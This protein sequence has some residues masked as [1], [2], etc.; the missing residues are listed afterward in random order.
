ML[1]AFFLLTLMDMDTR[2]GCFLLQELGNNLYKP[3]GC[4]LWMSNDV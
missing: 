1:E 2:V 3:L 4:Q